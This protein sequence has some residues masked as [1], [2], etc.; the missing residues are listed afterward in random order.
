VRRLAP[1]AI[2]VLLAGS[3]EARPLKGDGPFSLAVGYG[4]VWIGFGE[5]RVTR[6]DAATMQQVT[7]RLGP[8]PAYT[9]LSLAP[10]FGSVWAAPNSAPLFRLDRRTGQVQAEIRDQPGR[11]SGGASS[12]AVGGGSVW[13]ID[14][15]RNAVFRVDPR[16]NRVARR[17]ALAQTV[18][19]MVAGGSAVWLQTAPGR[20]SVTGP[21]GPRIVSR[22][23]SRTMRVRPAFRLDCDAT[24]QPLGRAVWVLNNCDGS[25]RRFDPRAARVGQAIE[26]AAGAFGLASGFG[27]LWVSTG[28]SVRRID[29]LRRSVIARVEIDG[30]FIA[31]GAGFIW[32]LASDGTQG[33]LRR[34]DPRTNR[35]VGR[36][37]RL[38]AGQ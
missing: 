16:T 5:G 36:P 7:R 15:Q 14:Y 37:L 22:L 10:G 11:W 29:P 31:A 30:Q 8:G 4:A 3:A 17:R 34:I 28:S 24:L 26:T 18:R 35:V 1:L 6:V 38:S 32:V 20:G 9:V 19:S 33:R 21:N 27:S 25:L 12:V 13:V 23:D 2:L